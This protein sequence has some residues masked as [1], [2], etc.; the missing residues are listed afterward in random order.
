MADMEDEA[1]AGQCSCIRQCLPSPSSVA[2]EGVDVSSSSGTSAGARASHIPSEPFL[3][4][5]QDYRQLSGGL[6]IR[7]A[8]LRRK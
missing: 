3:S 2:R 4:V 8:C 1:V 6:T 5:Y 7:K